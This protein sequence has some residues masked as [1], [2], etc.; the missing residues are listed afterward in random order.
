M[1][2]RL[3]QQ[4]DPHVEHLILAAHQSEVSVRAEGLCVVVNMNATARVKWRIR[5][6]RGPNDKTHTDAAQADARAVWCFS[7]SS[8]IGFCELHQ[9]GRI[10]L[11]AQLMTLRQERAIGLHNGIGDGLVHAR[12]VLCGVPLSRE[13]IADV[14]RCVAD[15]AIQLGNAFN[16][17]EI[18]IPELYD[19][20]SRSCR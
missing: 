2:L 12:S 19:F 7:Y 5:R 14:A 9:A 10:T 6:C 8:S 1:D 18:E 4:L 15:P 16:L 17:R 13:R 3:H 11:R 20:F